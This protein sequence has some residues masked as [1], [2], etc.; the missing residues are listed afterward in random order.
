MASLNGSYNS[1]ATTFSAS[2]LVTADN[3]CSTA[4]D[5]TPVYLSGALAFSML[6]V[7]ENNYDMT[8]QTSNVTVRAGAQTWTYRLNF[9]CRF[10]AGVQGSGQL[11]AIYLAPEGKIYQILDYRVTVNA[12]SHAL[13]VS[14]RF[15]HPDHGYVDVS[16]APGGLVA[17]LC[18]DGVYRPSSGWIQVMGALGAYAKL[19][20]VD[21]ASF[22]ICYNLQDATGEHCPLYAY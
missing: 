15:F 17:A 2:G 11:S 1:T 21:C 7:D 10:T 3:Y 16:T 18:P 13:T 9:S 6:G 12:I 8:L 22:Q 14:G 19:V 5:G 4:A 20:P